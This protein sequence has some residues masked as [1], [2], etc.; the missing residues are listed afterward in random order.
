MKLKRFITIGL[1]AMLSV[2]AISI[3][4]F[5]EDLKTSKNRIIAQIP[6]ENNK[7]TI[8]YE[9][10][11]LQGPVTVQ[12]GEY[13]IT[14]SIGEEN[15][16]P[17]NMLFATGGSSF[18]NG[19]IPSGSK[20]N[21]NNITTSIRTLTFSNA[22][23]VTTCSPDYYTPSSN[24]TVIRYSFEPSSACL[25]GG[26]GGDV[27]GTVHYG[28]SINDPSTIA[29]YNYAVNV[30]IRGIGNGDITYATA[31]NNDYNGIAQGICKISA[32]SN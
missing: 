10:E 11:L 25:P 12:S 27:T 21:P 13:E 7:K 14:V 3:N 30:T 2:S 6:T 24:Y 17:R 8:V 20:L 15:N 32:L 29:I 26:F 16:N 5:A 4:A 19:T 31:C 18:L 22:K 9:D 1:A 28:N 23:G